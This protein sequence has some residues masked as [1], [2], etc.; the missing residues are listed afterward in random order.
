VL[1]AGP[2][3]AGKSTL[4]RA[5][6]GVLESAGAGDLTGEV[7]V[8]GTAGLLLQNPADAIVADRV[9]RDV[10][11]GPENLRL[12]PDE[13]WTRVREALELVGFPYDTRAPTR[14]LSGG[15]TQRLA[16]AG[17]LAMRP[18]LLLLDEPTSY[19]DD[20]S[21]AE[22]RD[23]ALSVVEST[24]ATLVVAGHRIG[25]WLEH[26][27]RLVV[28]DADGRL[29][30]DGGPAE[31]L[32]RHGPALAA[33]GVWLP[34]LPPPEPV[35]V[36]LG[37]SESWREND[38]RRRS[39]SGFPT[40]TRPPT[41]TAD[42]P[43]VVADRLTVRLRRRSLTGWRESEA[44]AD[45]DA[46]VPADAVTCLTGR[47]GAGKSTL[48][49]ALGGFVRPERGEVRAGP[50][51]AAGLESWPGRWRSRELAG[52][53]GWVPQD[54]EHGFVTHRVRDEVRLTADRLD[55]SVDTDALLDAFGLA[56][57]ADASPYHL[58]GGEQRR[59]AL[60]AGLA[61]APALAL[62][63]EPTVGQDRNTWAA[64]AGIVR[65]LATRG[66]GVAIATHDRALTGV[67]DVEIVL[68]A[69]RVAERR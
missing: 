46:A 30:C 5:A 63:D 21:A 19:L 58:S 35:A 43:L 7:T 37:G 69:G 40:N 45:V 53:V 26:V 61:H 39:D 33:A 25:G 55:C 8:D 66:S 48:L 64:I 47:S 23:A 38:L 50:A 44:L 24:G 51:L 62:L 56:R 1:L 20:I 42:G 41:A 2:S 54:P 12:D 10:A 29:L 65:S 27:D 3:G 18:G 32:R 28:L 16:L 36:P 15:E 52:R 9:G 17:A 34:D 4:L 13:I 57:L 68:E 6:A 49:A 11:F 31:M 22:L 59:L 67:A 14:T 60:L